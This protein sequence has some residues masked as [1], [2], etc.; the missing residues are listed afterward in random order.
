MLSIVP[1]K[2]PVPFTSKAP[3]SSGKSGRA[4]L[5][6]VTALKST[7]VPSATPALPFATET[8]CRMPST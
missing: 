6:P 2:E 5:S 8:L 4:A 3:R 7:E 1:V